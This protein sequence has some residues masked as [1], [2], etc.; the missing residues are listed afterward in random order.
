M[1]KL[2]RKYLEWRLKNLERDYKL[3]TEHEKEL[4]QD[5]DPVATGEYL[6]WRSMTAK[7]IRKIKEKLAK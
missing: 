3:V 4:L 6:V 1:I 7:S 2:R 5:H